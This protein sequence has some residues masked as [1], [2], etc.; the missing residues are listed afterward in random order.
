LLGQA[1]GEL[2]R[3][4]EEARHVENVMSGITAAHFER[5]QQQAAAL[6]PHRVALLTG[7]PR[8]G[9]T[10]LEQVLGSHPQIVSSDEQVAFP[11]FI[12]PAMLDKTD[13]QPLR[14]ADLDAI[15]L[16]RIAAQRDRYLRYL[17]DALGQT[18]GDR[19]HIDKN[20]SIIMLIPGMLRLWP[21]CR[22]LIAIRDPR[23]VI[24]SCFMR[25]LP[26]NTVSAQ[27]LTIEGTARRYVRDI[28][29]WLRLRSVLPAQWLEV[30]YEDTVENLGQ[31]ARRS[32]EFLGLDWNDSVLDY[33]AQLANRQVNSPTYEDVAKPIYRSSLGRWQN[34]E[35]HLGP[36]LDQLAPFVAEFGY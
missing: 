20:P 4:E 11:K 21:E 13:K 36:V 25:Y 24:V 22:L 18:I 15:P 31:E 35:K 19:L 16:D 32:L 12:Y 29:A 10:L 14:T 8:S 2:Q 9:T 23:D 26:L 1:K 34:Y 6:P 27:F 7:P 5:W 30:R 33:R 3:A 28:E 17:A